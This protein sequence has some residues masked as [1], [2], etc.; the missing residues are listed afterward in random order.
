M[1][2]IKIRYHPDFIKAYKKRIQKNHKLVLQ[3]KNRIQLFIENYEDFQLKDHAL[4]GSR[5]G[6]R[7]FSVAG[8]VRIIYV[9]AS[10]S[11]VIFLDIGSHNQV[12]K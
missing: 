6:S 1:N 2:R 7:A 12:Y 3:T 10:E 5:K 4:S 11:E 9:R 8:D